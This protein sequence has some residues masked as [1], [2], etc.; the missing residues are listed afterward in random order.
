MLRDS[1]RSK[2][3][4]LLISDLSYSQKYFTPKEVRDYLQAYVKQLKL[5]EG[6]KKG[7]VKLDMILAQIISNK[8]LISDQ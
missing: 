8:N 7:Y 2:I 6:A 5:E 4:I 1:I 3:R